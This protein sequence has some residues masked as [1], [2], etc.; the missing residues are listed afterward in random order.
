MFWSYFTS[1]QLPL[2][3][4]L[5]QSREPPPPKLLHLVLQ[6]QVLLPQALL[7]QVF[8]PQELRPPVFLLQALLPLALL[9]Q[10]YPLQ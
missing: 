8:L 7:P 10:W 2:F 9:L 1:L 5:Q 6:F 4:P 3:R